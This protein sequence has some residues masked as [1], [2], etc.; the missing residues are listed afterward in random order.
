[1][2]A[3]YIKRKFYSD[4]KFQG[5]RKKYVGKLMGFG[6]DWIFYIQYR[7]RQTQ[8]V[9]NK[10]LGK[11]SEGWTPRKAAIMRDKFIQDTLPTSQFSSE[12]QP[13]LQTRTKPMDS[14]TILTDEPPNINDITLKEIWEDYKIRHQDDST[15]ARRNSEF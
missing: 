15:I 5:V 11:L 3:N 14:F 4:P 2:T 12:A 1:M 13:L 8:K 10:K 6:D 9:V 7:D